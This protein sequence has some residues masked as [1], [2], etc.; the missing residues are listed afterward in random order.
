MTAGVVGAEA[1]PPAGAQDGGATLAQAVGLLNVLVGLMLVAAILFFVGG[2][3]GWI[4]RLGLTGREQGLQFMSW[5]V[6]ILFVLVIGLGLIR[7]VQFHTQLVL[8]LLA[9]ALVA[10]AAYVAIQ[11]ARSSGEAEETKR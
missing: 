3:I 10:L 4:T 9:L 7:F 8:M 1:A 11:I 6:S 2:F 5:G